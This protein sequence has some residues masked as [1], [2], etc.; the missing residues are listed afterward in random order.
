MKADLRKHTLHLREGDWDYLES[1][2]KPN[3]IPTSVAVR[4]IVS[5]F[6]D[7]KRKEEQALV[8]SNPTDFAV[9]L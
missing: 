5:S 3:G 4:T 1:M 2:F 8:K 9:D 7:R 6:V